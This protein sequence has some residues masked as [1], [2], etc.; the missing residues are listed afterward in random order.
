[1][2][3]AGDIMRCLL[4]SWLVSA[5]V[6]YLC[7]PV[8]NREL[9]S[10]AG[11]AMMRMGK[12]F[13]VFLISFG[14]CVLWTVVHR[15]AAA[16]RW[17][18]AAVFAVYAAAALSTNFSWIFLAACLMILAVLFVYAVFGWDDAQP[19]QLRSPPAGKAWIWG[20][21]ALSLLLFL[22]ISAWT[23]GRVYTFSSPTFDFGI[24]S[25]MFHNMR[26]SGLPHTTVERDGLLSHFH[27]HVS[28][29]YYLM[30]PF[31]CLV[32]MP[33]T[34]QV[35]QAAVMVS[36]VIPLWKLCSL[37]GL[38]GMQRMLCCAL[39]LLFPAFS[40]GAGYDLH[41]NCFL[42]PLVLWLFYGIDRKNMWLIT[43]SLLLTLTVKEDAAVYGAVIGLWVLMNAFL[44]RKKGSG[45][46]M[47]TGAIILLVSV[48]WFALVTDFLAEK[49]DGVMTNRYQ[50]FMYGG[51]SS[52]VT[53][54]KAVLL[55]P[56]KA[57]FECVDTE[58]LPYIAATLLPLLCLPLLTRRFERY[59]LLIPYVLVNLMS[60]YTYQHDLFFQ[61]NFGSLACLFYLSVVNLSDLKQRWQR[62]SVLALAVAVSACCFGAIVVPKAVSYPA[63]AIQ[64]AAHY[65]EIREELSRIPADASVTATTGLTTPLSQ[66]KILY[67]IRYSSTEHL[68]QTEYAVLNPKAVADFRKYNSPGE[69]D[70]YE[71]LVSLLEKNG[72]ILIVALED[73][74]EIYRKI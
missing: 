37:H 56:M 73:R 17:C 11:I 31:Y 23:V 33:A 36:A 20:T 1:M 68:L 4:L 60:D 18:T 8:E 46:E 50:N 39:L 40:G 72:Y 26:E 62:T 29:I 51:S 66:R 13:L 54:L 61:Y 65:G 30:L 24:F 52:L 67:D 14:I 57:I 22:L 9:G 45:R 34:L 2:L 21:A 48:V 49:G 71:N 64:N 32:P 63:H 12:T 19:V 43:V 59:I 25:Q 53:V 15:A 5:A 55:L 42:T 35:L 47:V 41:E 38:T 3:R 70:G 6:S 44:H 27:V 28:P 58:K 10:T 69:T 16:Q 7:L 74:L